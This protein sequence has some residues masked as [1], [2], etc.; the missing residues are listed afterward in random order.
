MICSKCSTESKDEA[1]FCH[2]CG[3]ILFNSGIGKPKSGAN[4]DVTDFGKIIKSGWGDDPARE[5]VKKIEEEY[6]D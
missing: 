4:V 2:K 6:G 1:Q 5:I 3:N